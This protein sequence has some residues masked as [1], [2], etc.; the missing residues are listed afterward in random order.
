MIKLRMLLETLAP[1]TKIYVYNR[2][3]YKFEGGATALALLAIMEKENTD[4]I[5][6]HMTVGAGRVNLYLK[7]LD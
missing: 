6:K 5:V 3:T 2:E 1:S 7:K 4:G